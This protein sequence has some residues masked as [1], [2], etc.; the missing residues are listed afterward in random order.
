MYWV[1]NWGYGSGA[2]LFDFLSDNFLASFTSEAQSIYN[3]LKAIDNTKDGLY[4][5]PYDYKLF[6]TDD[7]TDDE[8]AKVLADFTKI[9]QNYVQP[10]FDAA[11]NAVQLHSGMKTW[12]WNY[13]TSLPDYSGDFVTKYDA[14]GDGRL[15]LRELL[16]GVI[17]SNS[18]QLGENVGANMFNST[19]M[20]F[21]AMFAFIDCDS[22]G[23]ISAEEIWKNLKK[24]VRP[25]PNN[26]NIFL[27]ESMRIS[28]VND[29]IL[30][31]HI[32]KNG[33]LSEKEFI[34]AL[35]LGFWNRQTTPLAVLTDNSRSLM[36]LRWN[37]NTND[38]AAIA[39][40]TP[41]PAPATSS[42][43]SATTPAASRRLSRVLLK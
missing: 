23:Y 6:I 31:N 4:T 11:I 42:S 36:D 17:D 18:K 2:Y 43:A 27:Y 14:D 3:A 32:S 22:D 28:S 24:L 25:N 39:A 21:K 33:L 15:N 1:K 38:I 40:T 41:P 13:D 7:M 20:K 37:N 19:A 10:I 5:D 29:F 12:K 26:Y 9:N 35:L 34:S 16:L 8:K 30:K